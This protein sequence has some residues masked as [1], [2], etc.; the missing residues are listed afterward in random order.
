M[1]KFY[2]NIHLPASYYFASAYIPEFAEQLLDAVNL[3]EKNSI[4]IEYITM[5]DN[6]YNWMFRV[7]NTPINN[8]AYPLYSDPSGKYLFDYPIKIVSN[9]SM[10][11]GEIFI[12]EN[13]DNGM[14]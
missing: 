12:V 6:T 1:I 3:C 8:G 5:N 7:F 11:D 2:K 4:F 14:A 10:N 13:E 9:N